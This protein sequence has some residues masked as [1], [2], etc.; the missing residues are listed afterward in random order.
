M[1]NKNKG[2]VNIKYTE[3]T[4]KAIKCTIKPDDKDGK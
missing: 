4:A 1:N 3:E 2:K